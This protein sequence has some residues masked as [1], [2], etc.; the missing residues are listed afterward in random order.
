[1]PSSLISTFG[2]KCL[3]I[4]IGTDSIKIAEI[5]G[6]SKKKYLQNYSQYTLIEDS[7]F[8]IYD[9]NNSLPNFEKISEILEAM[10]WK[11]GI[12]ERNVFFSIPDFLTLFLS[13]DLQPMPAQDIPAAIDFEARHQIPLP[14]SE[15]VYD[16]TLVQKEKI[17]PAVKAKAILV[18]VSKKTIEAFEKIGTLCN[19]N[20][21]GIEPEIFALIK[22]SFQEQQLNQNEIVCLLDIGS[23]STMLSL[24][25]GNEIL[26]SYS[27]DFG[28]SFL[29]NQ[30]SEVLQ[31]TQKE[32]QEL[33]MKK[34]FSLDKK[35][36]VEIL[37]ILSYKF[38]K[39]VLRIISEFNNRNSE[40]CQKIIATGGGILIPGFKEYLEEITNFN[41]EVANP[42]KKIIAPN[43]LKNYLKEISPLFGV[44][45]GLS[46]TG[47]EYID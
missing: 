28:G 5:A 40:K 47:L 8:K 41:F 20:I 39:E 1:M 9:P 14:L 46:L 21:V 24:V 26:N 6:F 32:A 3:G 42:F 22:S 37:K 30:L 12:K 44:A 16:W 7:A 18:V 13:I 4:D 38:S 31:I 35:E 25:Q 36:A 2:K 34:G 45:V 27:L 11:S 19:L 43:L 17:G 15:V 33:L 10:F 29:V 23:K